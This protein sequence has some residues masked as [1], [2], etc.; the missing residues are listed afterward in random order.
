MSLIYDVSTDKY[1]LLV[2][3]ILLLA[4]CL[5]AADPKNTNQIF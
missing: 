1:L 2:F 4:H 3:Q 5:I